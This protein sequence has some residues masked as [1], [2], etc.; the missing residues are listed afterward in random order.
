ME[1]NKFKI[2]LKTVLKVVGIISMLVTLAVLVF[3]AVKDNEN[4][5]NA[6]YSVG[7]EKD[8]ASKD[9]LSNVVEEE[10]AVLET[11]EETIREPLFKLGVTEEQSEVIKEDNSDSLQEPISIA[12]TDGALI[13]VALD[14]QDL[15]G[16]IGDNTVINNDVSVRIPAEIELLNSIRINLGD[17]L[18]RE[19]IQLKDGIQDENSV[20]NIRI[21]LEKIEHKNY[22]M[23]IVFG[24]HA[25]ITKAWENHYT[26][27][28]VLSEEI[29]NDI[30]SINVEDLI[31]TYSVL[32]EAFNTYIVDNINN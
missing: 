27:L 19:L 2:V 11:V 17:D 23:S 12:N 21:K 24:E 9:V 7:I 15:Q 1:D 3:F 5:G 13:N 4:G 31:S 14:N 8:I 6:N 29:K 26:S 20:F 18:I 22:L 10:V 32:N 30:N 28:T 25:D 16:E